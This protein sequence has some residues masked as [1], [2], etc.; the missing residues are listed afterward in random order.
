[1]ESPMHYQALACDYD[2]TLA[3]AGR[4]SDETLAAIE[5]LLANGHKLILVTGRE[6]P[7]L[8]AAFDRIDL[9][10][11][12]V[13]E[14]GALLYDPHT[15]EK[16][17]LGHAPPEKFVQ[18][19][20]EKSV[21]PLSA[22]EVIVSTREPHETTVLEVIRDLGLELRAILNKGAV[23]I[24]PAGISKA[25]GL[26]AALESLGLSMDQTVGVGDAE[27]DHAFLDAC[28]YSV[29]VAN[30]LESLKEHVDWVTQ[31]A[32]GAGVC[33]VIERLV[34]DDIGQRAR[35]EK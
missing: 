24:L 9:C 4:M 12:V 27:N 20:K 1:M 3:F 11:R 13:A 31:N 33:E 6:L 18:A 10:H 28:G 15:R 19:L 2:G 29:A 23:M 25:T 8:L 26:A 30:A 17:V 5:K 7:D 22:G 21:E 32:N 14:N 34:A 16:K 35:P